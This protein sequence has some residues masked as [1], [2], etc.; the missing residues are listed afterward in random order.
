MYIFKN[1]SKVRNFSCFDILESIILFKAMNI[2]E[3]TSNMK[4]A[5]RQHLLKMNRNI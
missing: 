2:L 1:Y 3:N 4:K 5:S